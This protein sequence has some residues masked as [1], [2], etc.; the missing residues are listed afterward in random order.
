M[1][2]Y[3]Y[4]ARY[5]LYAVF[6]FT[7]AGCSKKSPTEPVDGPDPVVA[8]VEPSVGTVGTEVKI[9]GSYFRPGAEVQFNNLNVPEAEVVNGSTIF[10]FAPAGIDSGM[11][12]NITVRNTDGTQVTYNNAFTAVGPNLMYVNS[13]TKPSGNT[14]ST[15]IIEGKAFGDI[16]GESVVLF[17]DGQGGTVVATIASPADWTDEFIITSVPQSAETG[18]IRVRTA[19]GLSKAL[20]FTVTETAMFSPSVINWTQTTNLP[21]ALS[22]HSAQYV[23]IDVNDNL[24]RYVYVFGGG[25]NSHAPQAEGYFAEIEQSGQVGSWNPTNNLPSPRA[26]HA[27]T[28]ATPFNSRVSGN[29]YV[30]VIGGISENNGQPSSTVYKARIEQNG[31]IGSWSTT[32]PLPAPLHSSGALVFRGYVYIAG[33]ATNENAPVNSVYRALID[34]LGNLSTWEAL[35]SLPGSQTYHSFSTFGG[36][37][38][39]VGGESG[40]VDPNDGNYINNDSKMSK[41][42]YGRINLR[43]G[44]LSESGWITNSAELTK[45]T[46]KHTALVAGGNVFVTAGLY[47]GAHTG[48]SENSYASISSDGSVGSFNGATGSN[49]INS[50]GGGNLFNHAGISYVDADGVARVMILGGDKINNPGNKSTAVWFY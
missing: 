15:V 5:I 32:T 9:T 47:N 6:I 24:S 40:S 23:P 48:S 26:F 14:G 3:K 2:S 4:I 36:F 20:T 34:T 16:Q 35:P 33:G 10:V 43:N 49:T 45:R 44:E 12:Y 29:G 41:V 8:G 31:S 38:Y 28:A 11:T 18:E 30:Y 37:L 1:N 13:A 17:S 25:D 50:Q 39:T 46:S 42:V 27:A 21:V 22:G 19:T 7:L